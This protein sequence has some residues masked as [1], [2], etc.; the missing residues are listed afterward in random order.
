MNAKTKDP[1]HTT[2]H[3]DGTVTC[4][5]VFNQT[6]ITS[7]AG[8]IPASLLAMLPIRERNRIAS[9]ARFY[10]NGGFGDD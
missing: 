9:R 5:N 4:W 6:G 1:F 2:F 7:Q 8:D 3:R 10:D